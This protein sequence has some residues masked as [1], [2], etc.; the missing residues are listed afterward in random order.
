MKRDHYVTIERPADGQDAAGQPLTTWTFVD[1][2]WADIRFL[3]G[4]E[5]IK[6]GAPTSVA[7]ASINIRYRTDINAGMRVMHESTEYDI[8]AVLPDMATKQHVELTCEVVGG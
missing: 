7:Q 2:E 1:Y 8:K 4:L 5:A 3:R 6:A